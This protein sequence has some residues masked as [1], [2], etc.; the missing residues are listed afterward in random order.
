MEMGVGG[1][2]TF[3]IKGKIKGISLGQLPEIVRL[4]CARCE[5]GLLHILPCFKEG[6]CTEEETQV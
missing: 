3:Q 5:P 2:L 4:L 1:F 6:Q